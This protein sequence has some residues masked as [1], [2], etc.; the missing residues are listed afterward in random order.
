MLSALAVTAAAA[1]DRVAEADPPAQEDAA[2]TE[3][4]KRFAEGLRAYDRG[5]YRAAALSFEAAERLAPHVDAVWNAARAWARAG[6]APR[7][8]TLYARYLRESPADADGR[9]LAQQQLDVLAR[10]LGRID[11]HGDHLARLAIDGTPSDETIVYVEPGAHIVDADTGAGRQTQTV[12]VGAGEGISVAF[13]AATT[14]TPQAPTA[15]PSA[16][17]PP[18]TAPLAPAP[19]GEPERPMAHHG[20]SPWVVVV[21]GVATAAVLSVT[22]WSGL[23]TLD[24]LDAFDS[25]PTP[26]NL[27]R[28]ESEQTR[29]NVLLSGTIGLGLLTGIAAIWLVDWHGSRAAASPSIA[30]SPSGAT[31][32]WDF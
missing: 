2:R 3:A 26:S 25:H 27:S 5:D 10:K 1:S 29:T 21:G 30:I 13:A 4:A 24:T 20:W 31:A 23:Q 32:R 6:E 7:A 11:V 15:V 28:G 9:A 17:A 12:R 16:G 22:I 14:S 8:A 18:V 19:Q